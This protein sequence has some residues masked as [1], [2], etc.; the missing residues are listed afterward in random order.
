[1]AGG[2]PFTVHSPTQSNRFLPYSP[3]SKSHDYN[4]NYDQYQP[5]HPTDQTPPPYPPAPIARSPHFP[6]PVALSSP[7]PARNG[8][9]RLPDASS[10]Y[11]LSST[12]PQ[13]RSQV[14]H[15]YPGGVTTSNGSPSYPNLSSRPDTYPLSPQ[16]KYTSATDSQRLSMANTGEAP[17][18]AYHSKPSSPEVI[19]SKFN[20]AF[21]H[22]NFRRTEACTCK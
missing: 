20:H 22:A 5:Q 17:S 19:A 21:L 13:H 7:P 11:R 14:L 2:Q 3:T 16:H 10:Q 1:M 4:Y 12:S 9:S 8:N 15:S 18:T 6:H